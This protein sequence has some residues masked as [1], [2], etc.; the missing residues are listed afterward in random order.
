MI[1]KR[2]RN[3]SVTNNIALDDQSLDSILYSDSCKIRWMAR[4][5]PMTRD[6]MADTDWIKVNSWL[7]FEGVNNMDSLMKF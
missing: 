2:D 1:P 6:A 7:H 4:F 5:L 3:T